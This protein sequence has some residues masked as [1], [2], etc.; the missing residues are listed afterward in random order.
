[1]SMTGTTSRL[2]ISRSA[3]FWESHGFDIDSRRYWGFI[4]YR[5]IMFTNCIKYINADN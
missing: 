4:F 5:K 2:R 3:L 1:M